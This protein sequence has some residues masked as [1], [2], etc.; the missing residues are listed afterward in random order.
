MGLFSDQCTECGA[1]VKKAARFCS[2]CGAMPPNGWCKCYACG[3]WVG[4]EAEFC[5]NCKQPFNP[6]SRLFVA[7][8]KWSRPSGIFAQRFETGDINSLLKNGLLIE[9]GNAAILMREEKVKGV[10]NPGRHDLRTLADRLR[11]WGADSPKTVV[12]V[13]DGDI[14]LPLRVTGL[15]TQEDLEVEFYAEG[16]VQFD[17]NAP[18]TLIKNLLLAKDKISYSDLAA[19]MT[20]ELQYALKNYC[21][22]SPID[23][24]FKNPDRRMLLE[25]TLDKALRDFLSRNGLIFVRLGGMDFTG[26]AYEKL[27]AQAGEVETA[28]RKTQLDQRMRELLTSDK[29]GQFKS[30]ADLKEYVRQLAQEHDLGNVDRSGELELLRQVYRHEIEVKDAEQRIQITIRAGQER[31]EAMKLNVVAR[32][33]NTQ[34]EIKETREWLKVKQEKKKMEVEHEREKGAVYGALSLE[35][36][37]AL[38]KDPA[39]REQLVKAFELKIK[40]G[41]SEKDILAKAQ[42]EALESQKKMTAENADRLERIMREAI[43]AMGEAAKRVPGI[44]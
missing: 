6:E 9:P 44:K 37:I 16:V 2:K 8:G 11:F 13:D 28:R 23:E 24:L 43:Q 34:Q 19:I 27:R 15:R 18:E 1:A 3:K 22:A 40:A 26:A 21:M 14:G 30:E 36:I 20:G 32:D 42:L 29:M 17:S 10:L 39:Q 38:S 33:I 41:I 12:M 31:I 4:Q 7:G 25:N 35:T 5:W